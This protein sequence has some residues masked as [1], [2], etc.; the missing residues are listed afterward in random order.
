[1]IGPLETPDGWALL[2][3]L[4]VENAELTF[5]VCTAVKNRIF[6]EWLRKQRRAAKKEWF[7]GEA[8]KTAQP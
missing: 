7:W 3:V 6:S 2:R 4:S 5:V 1:M 8:H